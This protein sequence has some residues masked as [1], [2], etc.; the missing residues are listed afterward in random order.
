[1]IE[2]PDR[3]LRDL[4]DLPP[5]PAL[6]NA[7]VA[8]R[9]ALPAL[10]PPVRMSV[11]EA[12]EKHRRVDAGGYWVDWSNDVAPYMLEP[13]E[14]QT[15]RL[16]TTE[17]FAGPARCVKTAG[18]IENAVAHAIMCAPRSVHLMTMT[19]GAARDYSLEKIGPMIEN[20]PDLAARQ[21]RERGADNIFDKRFRG[22]MRLTIGWP[23]VSQLSSRT[24]PL[25]LITEL[26]N[27][28][29]EVD[30]KGSP[31]I[32]AQ[33][34][35]QTA[36]S[37]A[38]VVAECSPGNP[39]LVEGWK[40]KT[41]H[42]APPCNGILAAYNKGTR[43]RWYCRCKECGGEFELRFECLRWPDEGTSAARGAAAYVACPECGGVHTQSNK[44]AL[45]RSGRW[46][47][48]AEDGELVPLG[49]KVRKTS[50]VSYWLHGP[51][52]VFAPWS[53]IVMRY[54]DALE[55]AE[56]TLNEAD[57]KA[58]TNLDL[59][60]PYTPRALRG[61]GEFTAEVLADMADAHPSGV[62][63]DWVRFITVSVDVQANRFVVQVDAWGVKLERRLIARF[64]VAAPP[65][66]APRAG[67]RALDPAKYDEDWEALLPLIDRE[68]P[69]KGRD[70]RLRPVSIIIDSQGAK[71]VTA[72]AY[73][74]WRRRRRA[75]QGKVWHLVRGDGGLTKRR[76]YR[77]FPEKAHG[78][79]A[80]ASDVPV[81]RAGTDL[82]KD[83]V[84]AS[85]LRGDSGARA[86]HLSTSLPEEIFDEFAAERRTDKGWVLKKGMKRNEALDLAVYGL[87][88]VIVLKAEKISWDRPPVWAEELGRNSFAVLPSPEEMLFEEEEPTSKAPA[89][90][91]VARRPRR[92]RGGSK[93]AGTW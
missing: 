89:S 27:L 30:D 13:M 10:A 52:A 11:A 3:V 84:T 75:G 49:E 17:I 78:G 64:D 39:V 2:I 91:R 28:R 38:M 69:V 8:L 66:D 21:I 87:A 20:S 34:R 56:D 73:D 72:R 23:V 40:P 44:G 48:E 7:R 88:L 31:L 15:S 41:P 9:L 92:K 37:A 58:V 85:L 14:V 62:A 5:V 76:A 12:A 82:L 57:L 70:E 51:A 36:G 25:V 26:D 1:M 29:A 65:E 74:F 42:E 46:L 43:A 60:L 81:V 77:A 53:E 83:E 35:T 67:E 50:T 63:P 54:L 18:L 93:L 59:G 4:S 24:I 90:P 68:W 19:Q 33:K 16:Y 6:T 32:Q 80:V 47:H 71:G 22:G 79:K 61:D 86:Y 55:L 45:I